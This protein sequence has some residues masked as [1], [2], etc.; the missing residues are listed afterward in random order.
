MIL[1]V[2]CLALMAGAC[3]DDDA[4][5]PDEGPVPDSEEVIGDADGAL[6]VIAED[7]KFG[8]DEYQADAG[9]VTFV[10]EN[11]G[12]I[13]HTLLIEEVDDF[14]L[15]VSSAGDVDEG[16]VELEP[17]DYVMFC[18]VP[19]HRVAGMEAALVVP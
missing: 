6:T 11:Q 3:G 10:Y 9:E 14:E 16:T 1:G 19:G 4:A 7:I 8:K 13:V 17:G 15:T 18:D 2:L 12:S 5:G